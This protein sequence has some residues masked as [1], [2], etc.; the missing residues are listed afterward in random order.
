MTI[1][2]LRR[3]L[4][5]LGWK[6]FDEAQP[7]AGGRWWLSARSCGHTICAL[8]DTRKEVWSAACATALKLN[9]NGLVGIGD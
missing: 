3:R 1:K 9:R 8:G 6:T 7:Q 5:H 4:E 2:G